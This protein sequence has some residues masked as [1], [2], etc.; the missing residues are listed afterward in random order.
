MASTLLF[1]WTVFARIYEWI[2]IDGQ[3]LYVV[4]NIQYLSSAFT[5]ISVKVLS[6]SQLRVSAKSYLNS[7]AKPFFQHRNGMQNEWGLSCFF[8]PIIF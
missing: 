1:C 6:A 7:Q 8:T 5:V 3:K 2:C 4:K